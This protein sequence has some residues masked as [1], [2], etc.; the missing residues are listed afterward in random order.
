MNFLTSLPQ[1]ISETFES[2]QMKYLKSLVE[3]GETFMISD[4]Q[5]IE[6]YTGLFSTL[7]KNKELYDQLF[8]I[9]KILPIDSA[10]GMVFLIRL[11]QLYA[12]DVNN[13][14]VLV[15]VA[16]ELEE[17]E[18]D[19]LSY[20]YYIG[21]TLNNLRKD[22][23][24]PCFSLVYGKLVCG[25]D[26]SIDPNYLRNVKI[27]DAN[28]KE[29]VHLLYEYIRN[30]NTKRTISLGS[31]IH[32]LINVRTPDDLAKIE[33]NVINILIMILYSLQVAYDTM[34][35]VH[36]DLHLGNVL[37]VELDT[38]ERV[39][40]NYKGEKMTIVTNVIPYIIDYGRCHIN[41]KYV[42]PDQDGKF[43][44]IETDTK[45][46][47]FS[48][49]KESLFSDN[50]MISD[51][52]KLAIIDEQIASYVHKYVYKNQ[53]FKDK[54]DK[55][56]YKKNNQRIYNIYHDTSVTRRLKKLIIDNIFNRHTT[57]KKRR[58]WKH[59]NGSI[60]TNQYNL[61]I[62]PNKTN[63]KYDFYKFTR[64]VIKIMLES[65]SQ[66]VNL[67]VDLKYDDMWCELDSQLD[68]E[69]PFYDTDYYSLPC[70]YH[71]TDYITEGNVEIGSWGH[72][73]KSSAD[74]GKILF[75]YIKDD[76]YIAEDYH[77]THIQHTGGD[78]ESLL[79]R[80]IEKNLVS[81]KGQASHYK[82]KISAYYKD[83]IS[84]YYKDKTEMVDSIT[85]TPLKSLTPQQLQEKKLNQSSIDNDFKET[86]DFGPTYIITVETEIM[87]ATK[88]KH[89]LYGKPHV[90]YYSDLKTGPVR[91]S[92]YIKRS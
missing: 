34:N 45:H 16:L 88:K 76:I 9:V 20:E 33:R 65:L 85:I 70:D 51:P 80:K 2:S 69:Y 38:P 36:Y 3:S 52:H 27:C 18:A 4:K 13:A 29:K 49:Y 72:W 24:T 82:D 73:I 32:Q 89:A 61:G 10:N 15:K 71:I 37:I 1:Y 68:T 66:N 11:K 75:S 57:D 92:D 35:F 14:I 56:Y 67:Q 58:N 12:K 53:L 6:K 59:E 77:I 55:L 30:V 40:I 84:A 90:I 54:M 81:K 21:K 47:S 22:T 60:R 19:S 8:D 87:K 50:Y 83:K 42:I 17:D 28:H 64:S 86:T 78:A 44:D 25:F 39:D 63:S 62:K 79:H 43:H 5:L 23:K 7:E 26:L 41:D 31:Y 46:K 48:E 91:K 74:V